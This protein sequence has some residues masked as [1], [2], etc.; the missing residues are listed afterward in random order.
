LG[1]FDKTFFRRYCAAYSVLP[2]V[3][4]VSLLGV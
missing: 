4:F 1:Q 3:L 2:L